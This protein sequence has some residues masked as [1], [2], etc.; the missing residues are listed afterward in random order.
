LLQIL[1]ML[2]LCQP[3]EYIEFLKILDSTRI[4]LSYIVMYT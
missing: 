4:D 1:E 2:S 3:V